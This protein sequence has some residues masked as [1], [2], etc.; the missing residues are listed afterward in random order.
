MAK[1]KL[2]AV[3]LRYIVR[4]ALM[5][6]T[7][8]NGEILPRALFSKK[9]ISFILNVKI[10]LKISRLARVAQHSLDC[11]TAALFYVIRKDEISLDG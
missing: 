6:V 5:D 1:K 4:Y 3:N 2:L 11:R 8:V 9:I 7:R 10:Y